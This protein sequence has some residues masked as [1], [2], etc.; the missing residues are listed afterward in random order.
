MKIILAKI[1]LTEEALAMD[2]VVADA[3]NRPSAADF[4]SGLEALLRLATLSFAVRWNVVSGKRHFPRHAQSST[5]L[6][7]V[8]SFVARKSN[9]SLMSESQR[10]HKLSSLLRKVL[11]LRFCN[12]LRRRN[13]RRA[14]PDFPLGN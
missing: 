12:A 7:H 8:L 10:L 9:S 1:D 6:R 4:N 11:E 5:V 3:V 14:R 2:K 13:D